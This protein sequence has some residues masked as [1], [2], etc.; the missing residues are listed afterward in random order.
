MVRFRHAV[1]PFRPVAK[2][3][4]V[5][6][7]RDGLLMNCLY[8]QFVNEWAMPLE[9][10]PEAIRRLSAWLN[11]EPDG[12]NIPFSAKGLYVHCPIEVRVSDSTYKQT[13]RPFLDNSCAH[14]PTLYLN[15]TLY[16]AYL[17]DPPCRQRYY[18]AFE[19]L[20][21]DLGAKP[22]YAKNFSYTNSEYM[23]P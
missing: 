4:A 22:H 7:L 11:R 19:W 3:S 12:G 10:G 8:S 20:M 1:R 5:E 2:T 6:E 16:R 18:E 21:R 9:K 14:G 23:P 13:P 17:Q 15:A